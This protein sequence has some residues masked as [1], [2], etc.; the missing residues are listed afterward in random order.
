MSTLSYGL[1]I[2][3]KPPIGTRPAKRKTIFDDD[4]GPEDGPD[5]EEQTVES[6]STLGGLQP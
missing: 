1:N 6:I 2:T 4:S 5:D 3:K